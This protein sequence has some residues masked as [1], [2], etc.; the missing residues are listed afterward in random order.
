VEKYGEGAELLENPLAKKWA[1][2]RKRIARILEQGGVHPDSQEGKE[3][4]REI[5][6]EL[7]PL[8]FPLPSRN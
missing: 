5:E 6:A 2:R 3:L 8:D 7:E 4:A 1:E